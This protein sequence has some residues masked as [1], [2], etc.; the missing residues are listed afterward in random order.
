MTMLCLTSDSYNGRGV[1]RSTSATNHRIP[2][3]T[4][5]RTGAASTS[6][7]QTAFDLGH[8]S[9][10]FFLPYTRGV[11]AFLRRSVVIGRDRKRLSSICGPARTDGRVAVRV[12]GDAPG[13]C[14]W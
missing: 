7:A 3:P 13:S 11:A 12:R 14:C 5:R 10:L 6:T 4:Q 2:Q 1:S 9:P 8:M